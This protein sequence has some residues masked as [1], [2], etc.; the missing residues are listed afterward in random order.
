MSGIN[1]ET[2]IISSSK[3]K[4]GHMPLSGMKSESYEALGIRQDGQDTGQGSKQ[5]GTNRKTNN[6][7]S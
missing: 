2:T 6:K 3:T 4:Q 1:H 5:S 7:I